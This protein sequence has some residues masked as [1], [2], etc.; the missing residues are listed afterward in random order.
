M[1][2][3]FN[4][5]CTYTCCTANHFFY[6]LLYH[7][8]IVQFSKVE[9]KNVKNYMYLHCLYAYTY[10]VLIINVHHT[11]PACIHQAD[12]FFFFTMIMEIPP[13]PFTSR[14]DDILLNG[15]V[16]DRSGANNCAMLSFEFCV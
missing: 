16:C 8:N 7:Q 4:T 13:F 5:Y 10:I 9:K 3:T 12:R 14:V 2:S 11:Y 6:F 1:L 15:S